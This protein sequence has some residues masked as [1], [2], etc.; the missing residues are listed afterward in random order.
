M[1]LH[2]KIEVNDFALIY[3]EAIRT[4]PAG[5]SGEGTK[6]DQDTVCTYTCSVD[7][8][9]GQHPSKRGITVEHRY[10]DGP[11]TLA[12]RIFTEYLRLTS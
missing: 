1:T 9:A 4:T 2:G 8:R 10:G 5:K 7:S 11:V 12:S 3:W 6:P